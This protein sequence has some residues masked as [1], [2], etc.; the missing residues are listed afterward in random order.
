MIVANHKAL[1]EARPHRKFPEDGQV[2]QVQRLLIV[3][4]ALPI[5]ASNMQINVQLMQYR[6]FFKLKVSLVRYFA[7]NQ[8]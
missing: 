7:V 4:L 1:S 6:E 8:V 2:C 5:V 3:D